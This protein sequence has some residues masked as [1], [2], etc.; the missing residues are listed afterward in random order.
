MFLYFLIPSN[1]VYWLG[2]ARGVFGEQREQDLPAFSA[3]D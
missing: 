3:A 1:V 2:W